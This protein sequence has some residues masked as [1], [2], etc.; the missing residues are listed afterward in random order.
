[1]PLSLSMQCTVFGASAPQLPK[2]TVIRKEDNRMKSGTISE[3]E[4][5]RINTEDRQKVHVLALIISILIP[6]F[7]GGFSAFLTAE[8]MKIYDIFSR[9]ALAPPS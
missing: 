9:P 2:M 8:D 6:L 4:A 7:V 1:M 5:V 3:T